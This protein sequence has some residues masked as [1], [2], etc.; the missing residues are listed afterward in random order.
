M[1]AIRSYY[2]YQALRSALNQ[3]ERV[4]VICEQDSRH[5]QDVLLRPAH[6]K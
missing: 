5:I 4:E 2:V 1:Y 3:G 6:K